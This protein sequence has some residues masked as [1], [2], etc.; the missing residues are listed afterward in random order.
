MSRRAALTFAV[1]LTAAT[2]G[3]QERAPSVTLVPAN[4]TR[5]DVA[6]HVIWLGEHRPAESFQW[7][8]WFGVAAAGGNISYYWTTHLKTEVELSTSSEGEAYSVE[9]ITLPGVTT[10]LYFQRDHEIRFTTAS[11]GLA[12]Q[13]FENAWFHP[14]VSAGLELVR[15]REHIEIIPPPVPPR[16]STVSPPRESS[17]RVGYSG[18]PYVAAGFKLY[19]SDRAFIRSDI[20]TSWSGDGLAALGWR[21]GVGIDF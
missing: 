1:C 15:E 10:P 11:S 2:V 5:W 12:T 17:T 6:A 4:S 8:R 3:A 14:F 21:S 7:D 18:R 19:L 20:R 13:F 16:G 9:V